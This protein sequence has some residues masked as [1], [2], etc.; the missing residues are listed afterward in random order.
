[1][2]K[3]LIQIAILMSLTA[4]AAL[5]A[6]A[7]H[8]NSSFVRETSRMSVQHK[9]RYRPHD[10]RSYFS[11]IRHARKHNR[12][13][14]RWHGRKSV[15]HDRWHWRNDDRWDGYYYQDHADIHHEQRHAESNFHHR[16][17]RHW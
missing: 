15:H 4:A 16:Q 14:R 10:W 8:Q 13:H 6:Y 9:H 3:S 11:E 12:D 2:K 1:M 7:Q 17:R 5:P